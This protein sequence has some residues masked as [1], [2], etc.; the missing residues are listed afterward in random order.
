MAKTEEN[1]VSWEDFWADDSVIT[2]DPK[3]LNEDADEQEEEQ[4]EEEEEQEEVKKPEPVAEKKKEVKK[5]APKAE[6]VE[7]KPEKSKVAPAKV[8][9][10][11]VVE[12][13]EEEEQEEEEEG[14]EN[15]NP[16]EFYDQVQKIT[17]QEV[18]VDYG[19]V[20]PLTPQGVALREKAVRESALE[21][22]LEEIET[23]FPS[24]YRALQHAY[25]GG[26]IADLFRA[27]TGRDYSK[28]EIGDKDEALATD[29]L[30]EYYR[31]KGVKNEAKIQR[32]I[33]ADAD[34]DNGLVAEAKLALAEL[35]AEQETKTAEVLEA[36]KTKAAEQAK[37]DKVLVTAI[38]EVIDSGKVSNFK[39]ANRQEGQE[40]KKF[41]LQNIRKLPDGKYEFATPLDSANLE[42]MIQYQYFQ[43]KK[44]DLDKLI[45]IK[46]N[47]KSA[48]N[49]RL[50]LQGEQAATKKGSAGAPSAMAK[51]TMDDFTV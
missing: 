7:K 41:L 26:D 12:E 28:I 35:K 44:G 32:L 30:K 48:E 19:G 45:A 15:A 10:P 31:S 1:K 25:N 22:F 8:E 5:E 16:L 46:A 42:K 29:V 38:E 17:G 47:S 39:L 50:K 33:D 23:K 6:K 51:F 14:D 11:P 20:D 34:S 49:L 21:N 9:K 4:E 24:A 13:Q 40:F 36:Q 43:Y 37:R 18:E 2:D 27:A 3:D